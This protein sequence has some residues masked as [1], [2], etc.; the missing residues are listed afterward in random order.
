MIKSNEGKKL[1][2]L[3]MLEIGSVIN[4]GALIYTKS[5]LN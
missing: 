5:Y 2:K 3:K 4:D 1:D